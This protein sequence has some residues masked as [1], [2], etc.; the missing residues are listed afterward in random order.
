MSTTQTVAA[1]KISIFEEEE[2]HHDIKPSFVGT[3]SAIDLVLA[4]FTWG[5]WLIVPY[6]KWRNTGYVITNRRLID[7]EGNLTGS[8]TEEIHFDTIYGDIRT[9]QGL[10][11]G[12]LNKGTVEFEIE[13][14]RGTGATRREAGERE[15]SRR[16]MD[17]HRQTIELEGINDYY[18]VTN[19][20]RRIANESS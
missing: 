20:I 18:E 3:L 8:S 4:I 2:L 5:F 12:L 9:S 17:I 11:E 1:G 7:T 15:S 6:L 19:T 10:I 16:E 14:E 13:K